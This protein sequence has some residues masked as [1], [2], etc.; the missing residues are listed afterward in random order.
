VAIKLDINLEDFAN[1]LYVYF[2]KKGNSASFYLNPERAFNARPISPGG[3]FAIQQDFDSRYTVVPLSFMRDL[4][5]E[6]VRVTSIEVTLK[7]NKNTKNIKKAIKSIFGDD[8]KVKDRYE[9]HQWLYKITKSE[10]LV[11][12]L[13]LSLILVIAAFNLIGS[14]LMLSLEKK[15]DMMILKSMG[16]E[17][18][19]IRNI[20]FLEGIILSLSA[21]IIGIALGAFVCWLQMRFGFVKISAGTTFVID[22]YPVSFKAM[23]FVW[24]FLSALVV[25]LFSSWL[26]ARTAY[27]ELNVRDIDR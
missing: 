8:Y 3:V 14:L 19:L 5:S 7:N 4:V 25:G 20:F 2:P 22:A 10:K 16:A 9:Q 26:P 23:D 18:R 6:P 21:A 13:I 24:V 1:I 12:F 17:A 11:V 15:K 27:K